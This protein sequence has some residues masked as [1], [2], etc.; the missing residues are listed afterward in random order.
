MGLSASDAS[1]AEES[2]RRLLMRRKVATMF[3]IPARTKR[4]YISTFGLLLVGGAGL[5]ACSG[6]GGN[7]AATTPV[8]TSSACLTVGSVALSWST[9][10]DPV[11]QGYL[12][13]NVYYGT[14]SGTYQSPVGVPLSPASA[15]PPFTASSTISNLQC[16]TTYYFAVA[17]YNAAGE[18]SLSGEVSALI[19]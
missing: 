3:C 11:A 10:D 6:G 9:N 4:Y 13:Y 17:A 1:W 14:A 2:S 12:G 7:Q 8:V 19:P 15:G 18:S 5:V 16:Q